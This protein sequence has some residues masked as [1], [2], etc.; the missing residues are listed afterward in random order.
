M[1]QVHDAVTGLIIKAQ[2][3]S[4]DFNDLLQKTTCL[5]AD[6]QSAEQKFIDCCGVHDDQLLKNLVKYCTDS[7]RIQQL[8]ENAELKQAVLEYREGVQ[9]IMQKYKEHC[10]GNMLCERFNMRERYIGKL[11]NVVN[12][13]DARL[14]EMTAIM[15]HSIGL[16]EDNSKENQRIIQQLTKDNEEMRRKLQIFA[17]ATDK[18]FFKHGL[19][20]QTESSTQIESGDVVDSDTSSSDSFGS[21]LTCFS[22]GYECQSTD[23][24]TISEMDGEQLQ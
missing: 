20:S 24:S 10:K 12:N 4:G 17:S 13:L 16:E 6:S 1:S 9:Q 21:F 22:S 18:D 2:K 5:L 3:L 14:E 15:I 7:E 19:P 23:N 11:Q 8:L